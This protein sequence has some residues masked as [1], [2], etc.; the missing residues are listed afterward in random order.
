MD[1]YLMLGL[2]VALPTVLSAQLSWTNRDADFPGLPEGIHVYRT[3][4]PI[5][6]RPNIAWYVEARLK[7]RSLRFDTD[8]TLGRRLT[9]SQFQARN[10]DAA[11]VVNGTFFSFSDHRNLNVLIRRGRLVGYNIMSLPGKG[12]DTLTYH[13][14]TRSAIGVDRKRRADVAWLYTDSTRRHALAYEDGPVQWR[15]SLATA[16]ADAMPADVSASVQKTWRKRTA[17]GG[18]PVLVHDGKL[19]ITNNEERMFMGKAREDLH[20]RTAM[21]YTADGRLLILAV[22]GRH[23]GVAE[24]VSLSDMAGIFLGLGAVEALNLD[25]GGSSCLLVMGKNTIHPSDKE[26]QR[27]VPG[28][29]LVSGKRSR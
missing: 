10:P 21:G 14:V 8:S 28:V 17:I 12:R 4:T 5:D 19:R 13:H 7:D 3:E 11:V 25:G 9:P 16:H 24:G 18:G 1:R 2:C 26:G 22:E 27:A 23:K 20:P 15:D 6:G 29:F